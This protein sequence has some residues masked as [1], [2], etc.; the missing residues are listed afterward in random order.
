MNYIEVNGDQLPIKF[1]YKVVRKA[2]AKHKLKKWNDWV[3]I[4]TLT[5]FD[6]VPDILLGALQ[7]GAK[8][9]GEDCTLTRDDVEDILDSHPHLV[10]QMWEIFIDDM[11][12]ADKKETVKAAIDEATEKAVAEEVEKN[13]VGIV[14]NE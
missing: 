10:T 5:E 2:M 14:S 12:P 4:P 9:A 8:T 3:Q 6:D 11:T 1:G 7:S 13:R